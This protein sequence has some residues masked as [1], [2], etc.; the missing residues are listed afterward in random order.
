MPK[1]KVVKGILI[2]AEEI[3]RDKA[4][5]KIVKTIQIAAYQASKNKI[6]TS[7]IAE[8]QGKLTSTV[9]KLCH[10]D[11]QKILKLTEASEYL[12]NDPDRRV[13]A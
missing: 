9:Y 13:E 7:R 10:K 4:V 8:H 1:W 11:S 12:G 5:K 6:I 3:D 2:A